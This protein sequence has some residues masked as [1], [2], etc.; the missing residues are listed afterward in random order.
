MTYRELEK[1]NFLTWCRYATPEE[2]KKAKGTN[3][4]ELE[5]LLKE[6]ADEIKKV[7][8]S[9]DLYESISQHDEEVQKIDLSLEISKS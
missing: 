4:K 6:Y 1:Q 7:S 2:I 5:R 9:E 8:K 3:K